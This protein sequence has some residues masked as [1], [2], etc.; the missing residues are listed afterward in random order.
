VLYFLI[1][2]EK[3]L[4]KQKRPSAKNE[5]NFFVKNA[6]N[7]SVT[8]LPERVRP[9]AVSSWGLFIGGAL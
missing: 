8:S 2:R 6:S 9:K 3:N 7:E 1:E 4:M 5:R